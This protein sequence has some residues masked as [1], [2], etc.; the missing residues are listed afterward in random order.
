[1]KYTV[2]PI[3]AAVMMMF[4]VGCGKKQD[5]SKILRLHA[6]AGLQKPIDAVIEAFKQTE[7]GADITFERNY[8]GSAQVMAQAEK[9]SLA[10]LF[11]P[12]DIFYINQ[13]EKKG[14]IESKTV[15]GYFIPVILVKKGNKK[16]IASL[17][18]LFRSDVKVGLGDPRS[19]QVGRLSRAIFKKNN[20]PED[21]PDTKN[22]QHSLDVPTLGIWVETE[23]VDAAIVW[24]TIGAN[25][26]GKTEMIAI[27]AE[28][29]K[30][31]TPA[32]A[33]LKS[34]PN[35]AL[36]KKFIEFI[37]SDAGKAVL[38]NHNL[39]TDEPEGMD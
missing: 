27:P 7:A 34:S 29:N 16:G 1:M 4:L 35:K 39:R 21:G 14:V 18:D 33:L 11:L 36:A 20:L 38:Q 23:T 31:S 12:G 5:R 6:G 2:I 3:L 24:D 22:V 15:V 8:L 19:C 13:L 30:I 10:D 9:D 25:T 17:K 32:I 37:T 28:D 26:A